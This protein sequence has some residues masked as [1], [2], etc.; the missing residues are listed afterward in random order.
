MGQ[1]GAVWGGG[2]TGEAAVVS[3]QHCQVEE[4]TSG[5]ASVAWRV[6]GLDL[7][8]SGMAVGAERAANVR[9]FNP[10]REE[11]LSLQ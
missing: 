7:W 5:A 1:C 3:A 9:G 4:G 11:S 10:G 6:L 8:G 2:L